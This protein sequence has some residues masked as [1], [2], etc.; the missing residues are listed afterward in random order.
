MNDQEQLDIS[1]WQEFLRQVVEFSSNEVVDQMI[2]DL[3]AEK[4]A[5]K[6]ETKS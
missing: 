3:Q 5:R 6:L 4:N 2:E 1:L